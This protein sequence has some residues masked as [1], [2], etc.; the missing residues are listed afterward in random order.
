MQV[1]DT[2]GS[3]GV[4]FTYLAC[5]IGACDGVSM[6]SAV[7]LMDKSIEKIMEYELSA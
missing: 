1:E 2:E 5:G 6:H 3:F 4:V 7:H